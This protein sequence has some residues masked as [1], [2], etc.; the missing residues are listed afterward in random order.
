M[1]Y[2]LLILDDVNTWVDTLTAYA[3]NQF[4]LDC[5]GFN[6][7]KD[8][9]KFLR[10]SGELPIGYLI[11][12]RIEGGDEELASPLEIYRFLEQ[13]GN[14]RHFSFMTGNVSDHDRYV[15]SA[16]GARIILKTHLEDINDFL[17]DIASSR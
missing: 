9:L 4:G 11:D 12:M 7:G 14:N 16:T 8:T 5:I 3:K 13:R 2:D 15:Q 6:W 10:E 1:P 17:A